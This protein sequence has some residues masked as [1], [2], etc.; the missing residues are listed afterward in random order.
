MKSIAFIAFFGAA[1][2]AH[3]TSLTLSM[4][5]DD[6]YEAYISTSDAVQGTQFSAQVNTWQFGTVTGSTALTA[7]MTNYLHIR[8]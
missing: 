7:G 8:A 1:L 2:G 4:V 3:A 5:A 6:Y